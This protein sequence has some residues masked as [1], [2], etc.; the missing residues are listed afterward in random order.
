MLSL[1]FSCHLKKFFSVPVRS[2]LF[3]FGQ[4]WNF[5]EDG[6][7]VMENKCIGELPVGLENNK[8]KTNQPTP[9]LSVCFRGSLNICP[10]GFHTCYR[11]KC[12]V[13]RSSLFFI[14]IVI[15]VTLNMF[16]QCILDVWQADDLPF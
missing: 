8:N 15:E 9:F 14:E 7:R 4:R 13:S 6:Q 10:P 16:H 2:P 3:I 5:S 1:F 12:C 11:Q